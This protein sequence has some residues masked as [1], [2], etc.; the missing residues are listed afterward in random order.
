MQRRSTITRVCVARARR[1]I[2]TRNGLCL[3]TY[4][5]LFGNSRQ[6]H[7]SFHPTPAHT[8]FLSYFFFFLI[9]KRNVF[10]ADLEAGKSMI[11]VLVDSVSSEN[12]SP[13]SQM[14]ISFLTRRK[15]QESVLGS[16]PTLKVSFALEQSKVT[17]HM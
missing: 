16:F 15:E 5:Q 10:L 6:L 12:L 14:V 3:M 13:G 7:S 8:Y 11:E 2:K 17:F 1:R 9:S 4:N